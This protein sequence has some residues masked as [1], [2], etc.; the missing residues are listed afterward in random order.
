MTLKMTC[1]G[2]NE[3]KDV[4][5]NLTE[6]IGKLKI[7]ATEA[8]EAPANYIVYYVASDKTPGV[9]LTKRILYRLGD[10]AN[11]HLGPPAERSS[12]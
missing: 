5:F 7:L 3:E 6:S 8:F 4:I 1:E 2:K 12:N 9:Y 11:I 10:T